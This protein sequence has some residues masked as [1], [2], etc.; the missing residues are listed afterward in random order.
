MWHQA[1]LGV[2]A[3]RL[4][5]AAWVSPAP[6]LGWGRAV[7]V[8]RRRP[9]ACSVPALALGWAF[10]HGLDLLLQCRMCQKI[11]SLCSIGGDAPP[12]KGC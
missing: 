2:S 9:L 3:L 12:K 11:L 7:M 6:N 8:G 5:A 4:P 1:S 10:S